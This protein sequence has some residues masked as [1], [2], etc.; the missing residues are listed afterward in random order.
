MRMQD[1]KEV[2]TAIEKIQDIQKRTDI[3][4]CHK[5]GTTKLKIHV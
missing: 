3:Q 1:K 5:Y 2:T 4:G